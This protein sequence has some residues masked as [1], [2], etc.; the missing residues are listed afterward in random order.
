VP[1]EGRSLRPAMVCVLALGA[2]SA[3]CTGSGDSGGSG[4]ADAS[5]DATRQASVKDLTSTSTTVERS[6]IAFHDEH[7]H[8]PRH[9]TL[10]EGGRVDLQG[11]GATNV[12]ED[13]RLK[14]GVTL[15]WY[16]PYPDSRIGRLGITKGGRDAFSYCLS[17][18]GMRRLVTANPTVSNQSQGK[19]ACPA[20]PTR[21]AG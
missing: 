10:K 16:R 8:Y 3:G 21:P 2:L 6:L 12:V 9:V 18:A 15:D 4:R 17:V 7:E 19:G 13:D 5:R 11:P 1:Q 20:P 14:S